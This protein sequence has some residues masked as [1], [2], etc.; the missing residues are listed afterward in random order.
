[1]VSLVVHHIMIISWDFLGYTYTWDPQVSM[2]F[3]T[4]LTWVIWGYPHIMKR[5][6]LSCRVAELRLDTISL[7]YHPLD[8]LLQSCSLSLL[9]W[10]ALLEWSFIIVASI[11][12]M[13]MCIYIYIE[14]D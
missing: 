8:R 4:L 2:S 12:H 13:Y 14:L 11:N 6:V 1:M 3:D 5:Y 7:G 9:F 10:L